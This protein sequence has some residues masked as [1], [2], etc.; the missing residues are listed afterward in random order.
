M[1]ILFVA[2]VLLST[3]S[4]GQENKPKLIAVTSAY[5]VNSNLIGGS[6]Y[7]HQDDV[8]IFLGMKSGYPRANS[9]FWKLKEGQSASLINRYEMGVSYGLV[10]VN[11]SNGLFTLNPQMAFGFTTRTVFERNGGKSKRTLP[12]IGGGIMARYNY[13][14]LGVGYES[15]PNGF[16]ISAGFDL[17]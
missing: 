4:F 2:I 14:V 13:F 12:N 9:T 6:L 15:N 5:N 3:I 7:V 16:F 1:R 11:T 10:R 8:S 17:H